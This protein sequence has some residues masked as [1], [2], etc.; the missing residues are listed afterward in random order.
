MSVLSNYSF[1]AKQTEIHVFEMFLFKVQSSHFL[2]IGLYWRDTI[3]KR[4]FLL[5]V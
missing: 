2:I 3:V 1:T 4:K 5:G